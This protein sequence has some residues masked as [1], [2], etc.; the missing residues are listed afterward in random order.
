MV[1]Q[2]NRESLGA[3]AQLGTTLC[4]ERKSGSCRSRAQCPSVCCQSTARDSER[5][6]ETDRDRQTETD[7]D[8]QRQTE[9]DRDRQRQT[10]QTGHTGHTHRQ[11]TH[12]Y[13][14]FEVTL[15][16]M[17]VVSLSATLETDGRPGDQRPDWEHSSS[18]RIAQCHT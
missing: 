18:H 14:G 16:I 9:T 11:N 6:T 3:R 15:K 8:R 7:R 13:L 2:V 4:L 17:Q 5:Q 12:T 10:G 1:T